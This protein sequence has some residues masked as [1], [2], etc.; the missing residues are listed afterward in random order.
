MA[1]PNTNTGSSLG[2]YKKECHR[3]SSVAWIAGQGFTILFL[4][5]KIVTESLDD[6]KLR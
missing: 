3:H 2:T 1:L 5:L 4:Y 6:I